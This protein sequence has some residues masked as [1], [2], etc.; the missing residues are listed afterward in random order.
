MIAINNWNGFR[1][2]AMLSLT[3]EELQRSSGILFRTSFDDLDEVRESA[4]SGRS[5]T[6][7]GVVEHVHSPVPG[8]ELLAHESNLREGALFPTIDALSALGVGNDKVRWSLPAPID[9]PV[10]SERYVFLMGHRLTRHPVALLDTVRATVR[11]AGYQIIGPW[12]DMPGEATVPK[13]IQLLSRSLF[14]LYVAS[15]LDAWSYYEIGLARGLR[16]PVFALGLESSAYA[17]EPF[18]HFDREIRIPDA[19]D[20]GSVRKALREVLADYFD[21]AK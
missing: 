10:L 19:L 6:V 2:F 7:Y 1:S 4:F 17:G 5:G 16:K 21:L 13:R 20:A 11:D 18:P 9:T 8:V 12:D 3:S 15:A 14:V